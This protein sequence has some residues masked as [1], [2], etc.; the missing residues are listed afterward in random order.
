MLVVQCILW[1]TNMALAC[2]DSNRIWPA[3]LF[4][5]LF[6]TATVASQGL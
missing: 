4:A 2:S 5:A 1:V 6:I 3:N